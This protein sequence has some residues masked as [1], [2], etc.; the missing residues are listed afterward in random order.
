MF[1]QC[2][3]QHINAALLQIEKPKYLTIKINLQNECLHFVSTLPEK[4]NK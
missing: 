1:F 3:M 2:H 4:G